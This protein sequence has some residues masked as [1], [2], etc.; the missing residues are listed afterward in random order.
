[1]KLPL[2]YRTR[3]GKWRVF[4]IEILKQ[5]KDGRYYLDWRAWDS[6]LSGRPLLGLKW[7]DLRR[8]FHYSQNEDV[9]YLKEEPDASVGEV[10]ER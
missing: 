8:Y 10:Q 4:P 6:L 1:M 2:W 3:E 7:S 5:A 9:L